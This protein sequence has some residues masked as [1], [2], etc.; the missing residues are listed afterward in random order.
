MVMASP[1]AVSP[2]DRGRSA[3]SQASANRDL[4]P[5]PT[6]GSAVSAADRLAV[7]DGAPGPLRPFVSM[8]LPL[9]SFPAVKDRGRTERLSGRQ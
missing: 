7:V 5:E 1:E 9:C 4:G 8:S 3:V 2:E 6:C